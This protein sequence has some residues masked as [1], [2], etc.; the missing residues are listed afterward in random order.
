MPSDVRKQP[1]L[2]RDFDLVWAVE[3]RRLS[4]R[5]KLVDLSVGGA[6]IQLDR[7]LLTGP[8]VTMSLVCSKIPVLPTRALI[9][10]VRQIK[11]GQPLYLYGLTFVHHDTPQRWID[12]LN[13]QK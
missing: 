1:R 4:G 11:P 9:K 6:C 10:W 5:G 12:W 2:L 3:T 7:D 13:A 8:N